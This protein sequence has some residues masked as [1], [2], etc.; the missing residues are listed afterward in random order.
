MKQLLYSDSSKTTLTKLPFLSIFDNKLI[1]TNEP[2]KQHCNAVKK[3]I[4]LDIDFNKLD[5][6]V[7]QHLIISR[8]FNFGDLKEINLIIEYYG[9]NKVLNVLCNINYLDPKTLNFMVKLFNVPKNKFKCYTR[10]PL[11]HQ[12]W[13]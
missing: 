3:P 8:V 12:H 4:F 11:K 13:S 1:K 6:E 10:I 7:D 5:A 9:R 2:T